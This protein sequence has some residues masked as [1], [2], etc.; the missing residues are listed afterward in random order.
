[1]QFQSD[2]SRIPVVVNELEELSAIGAAYM[3]GLSAGVW[4]DMDTLCSLR[5]KDTRFLPDM[6][7]QRREQL[8]HGWKAAV[9]KVLTK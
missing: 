7:E 9:A 1:M 4:P 3:G 8:Y 5:T 2:I 6:A